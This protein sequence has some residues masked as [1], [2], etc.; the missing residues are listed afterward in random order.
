MQYD[1]TNAN[2]ISERIRD[3]L[4][5][6]NPFIYNLRPIFCNNIF[7]SNLNRILKALLSF[8][9]QTLNHFFILQNLSLLFSKKYDLSTPHYSN[10]MMDTSTFLYVIIIKST[11]E[12]ALESND[13]MIVSTSL[14]ATP[15]FYSI[16]INF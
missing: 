16:R 1:L 11:L 13:F 9:W 5:P 2:K 7:H 4:P 3:G 10:S 12:Q 6:I 15:S 14:H 8:H